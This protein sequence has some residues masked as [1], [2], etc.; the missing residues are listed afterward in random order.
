MCLTS[1]INTEKKRKFEHANNNYKKESIKFP[2]KTEVK[3]STE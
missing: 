3:E 2:L 1:L